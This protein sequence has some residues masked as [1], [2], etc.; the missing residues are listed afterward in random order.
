MNGK[1]LFLA[2][3]SATLLVGAAVQASFAAP[4]GNDGMG[5]GHG[6]RWHRPGFSP[7]V[8]YVRM[9]KQFDTNGDMKISKDELKAGVDKIFDQID[10]NKDGE[11]TPAEVK[12]YRQ[13]RIKE[14]RAERAKAKGDDTKNDQAQAGDNK[15]GKGQHRGHNPHARFVREAALVR[16][17]LMFHRIDTDG[18]GQISKAEAEAAADKFFDRMDRNHDG[19]ISLDDMP[20]RPLL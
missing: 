15:G 7:E 14:W 12:A 11:I 13:E 8:A 19:V 9:L 20:N 3:L 4:Q 2:G 1:K 5:G 10:T 18:N 6:G 17:M 16:G